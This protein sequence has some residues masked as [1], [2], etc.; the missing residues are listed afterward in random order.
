MSKGKSSAA[1]WLVSTVLVSALLAWLIDRIFTVAKDN[2][3]SG[4]ANGVANMAR[5]GV[6]A[7]VWTA[8]TTKLGL[9]SYDEKTQQKG[10]S[11]K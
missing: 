6:F 9:R 11:K 4:A 1:G 10:G 2:L 3:L 8:V 7:G 5:P